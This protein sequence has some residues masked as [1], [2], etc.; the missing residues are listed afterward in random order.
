L[1]ELGRGLPVFWVQRRF[2]EALEIEPDNSKQDASL[3]PHKLHLR[4]F[5]ACLLI[6]MIHVTFYL[7]KVLYELCRVSH[8]VKQEAFDILAS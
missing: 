8:Q 7:V 3:L 6:R 5:F 1:V 4:L 2:I